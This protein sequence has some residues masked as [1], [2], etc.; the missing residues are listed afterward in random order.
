MN[1]LIYSSFDERD[2]RTQVVLAK[3]SQP[4]LEFY[5][6]PRFKNITRYGSSLSQ[7]KQ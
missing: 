2:H 5:Q 6:A 3:N 7:I 1:S 4:T